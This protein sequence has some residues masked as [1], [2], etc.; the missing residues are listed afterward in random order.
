VVNLRSVREIAAMRRS[1]LVVW[2][3]HQ[4]VSSLVRPGINTADIDRLGALAI[5]LSL[6][7]S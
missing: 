4:L 1:G 6:F 3:A 2:G 7:G 5:S